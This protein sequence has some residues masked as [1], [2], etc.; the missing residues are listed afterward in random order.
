MYYFDSAYIVKYCLND[1][2]SGAVRDL[3]RV[4]VPLY[5]SALCIP[6]VTCA[7][8]RRF[9][10]RQLTREQMLKA[11]AAFRSHIEM[12]TRTL[13]PLPESL[14]WN[15]REALRMLPGAVFIRSGDATHLS[16]ART[17]GFSEIWT[18]HRHMLEA[19]RHF[20]LS[21]RSV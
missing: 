18:S 12:G 7:I 6:E 1:P 11:P 4:P 2:D 13:I 17:A 9:R 20:R 5:S 16:S 10:E 19:A 15:V 8:H 14:L 3:V 21:G